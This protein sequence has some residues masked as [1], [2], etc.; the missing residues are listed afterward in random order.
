MNREFPG[1]PEQMLKGYL[2]ILAPLRKSALDWLVTHVTELP[3]GKKIEDMRRAILPAGYVDTSRRPYEF[4]ALGYIRSRAPSF[5]EQNIQDNSVTAETYRAY[6]DMI[7][8]LSQEEVLD[9]LIGLHG[10]VRPSQIEPR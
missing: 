4:V 1:V 2:G 5:K 10:T 3:T 8:G 9:G 7:D 6:L